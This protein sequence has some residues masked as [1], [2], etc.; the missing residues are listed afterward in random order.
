[1][2]LFHESLPQADRFPRSLWGRNHPEATK[3]QEALNERLGPA[4]NRFGLP[5]HPEGRN[6][7]TFVS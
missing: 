6:S 4:H 3:L 2:M 1:D 5:I 7:K